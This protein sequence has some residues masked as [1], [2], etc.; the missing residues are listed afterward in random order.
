MRFKSLLS[1]SAF[2][3]IVM[4]I[5]MTAV[6]SQSTSH[7]IAKKD[8]KTENTHLVQAGFKSSSISVANN[9]FY[10]LLFAGF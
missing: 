6:S 7:N 9:S 10:P 1:F 5:L 8:I 4:T 2:V 3:T